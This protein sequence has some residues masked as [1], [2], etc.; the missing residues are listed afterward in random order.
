[1][2]GRSWGPLGPLLH[3]SQSQLSQSLLGLGLLVC[4]MDDPESGFE[5]RA[6]IY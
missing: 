6:G 4:V 2:L 5:D 1:M 3:Q